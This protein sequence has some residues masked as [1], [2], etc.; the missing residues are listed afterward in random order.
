[1]VER[2]KKQL[3]EY[4]IGLEETVYHKQCQIK[5]VKAKE[6]ELRKIT[7][8]EEECLQK[9]KQK[10]DELLKAIKHNILYIN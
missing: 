9:Y 2:F 8:E 1:M 4:Q 7:N 10:K 3:G 6:I 5:E